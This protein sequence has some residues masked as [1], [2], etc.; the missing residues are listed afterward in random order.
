MAI[1]NICLR[2]LEHKTYGKLNNNDN[3]NNKHD[4]ITKGKFYILAVKERIISCF[5]AIFCTISSSFHVFSRCVCV[6]VSLFCLVVCLFYFI[7]CINHQ[8][9]KKTNDEIKVVLLGFFYIM[10]KFSIVVQF[11]NSIKK[12]IS[13]CIKF[14][15]KNSTL[16]LQSCFFFVLCTKYCKFAVVVHQISQQNKN[17][18]KQ[19]CSVEL[20]MDCCP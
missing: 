16:L 1:R 2:T 13:D 15:T 19:H 3:N 5:E 7:N 17:G 14:P 18:L 10:N 9:I 6:C 20:F 11:A 4:Q 8:L 12:Y